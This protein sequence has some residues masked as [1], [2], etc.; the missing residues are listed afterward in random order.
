MR[1]GVFLPP[2][3]ELADARLL[4]EL[5]ARAEA[6]GWDGVFLWDHVLYRAP[7]V[8]IAD[9]WIALAAMA[10]A[11]RRIILGALVTPLARRRPWIVAR[12]VTTL[13]RL[14]EGRLVLGG[15]LGTDRSGRELSSFGEEL[16]D[17]RRAAML[18]EALALIQ[19]LLTGED[20][21][22]HG[23]HYIADGVRM[24]PRPYGDRIL[25]VWMAAVW[26][27]LKP[28]RRA[29]DY[30][31]LF[32]IG[33]DRPADVAKVAEIV[34]QERTRTDGFELV[35]EG[36]PEDD[37]APMEASGATWWLVGFEP[38]TLER[39]AVEAAIDRGPPLSSP[40]SEHPSGR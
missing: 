23:H 36:G 7:V 39:S 21:S 8:A 25:P 9:P 37:P 2:F 15:G 17:R 4:A 13:D 14:A 34:S 33:T 12:Q 18:D 6:A 1:Y 20:V 10:V 26:P 27:H 30:Q 11:T 35:V 22:Y 16:D 31:G 29:L 38:F 19:Q 3:D 40:I 24:R 5:A 32:L 28:V